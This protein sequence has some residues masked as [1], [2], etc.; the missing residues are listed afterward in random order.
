MKMDKKEFEELAKNLFK[1]DKELRDD[2]TL[3]ESKEDI[4]QT[5][6]L[7]GEGAFNS[8]LGLD[9]QDRD[10]VMRTLKILSEG[11]C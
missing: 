9:W 1:K 5:I 2:A 7:I 6:N 4:K 11:E 10:L 8:I 3:E